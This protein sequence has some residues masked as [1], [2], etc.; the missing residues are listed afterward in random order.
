MQIISAMLLGSFEQ[1][2]RELGCEGGSYWYIGISV[3][4]MQ[5]LLTY[6]QSI[7]A[8]ND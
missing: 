2:E 8:N 5:E 6:Y 3:E 1:L 4:R 7:V